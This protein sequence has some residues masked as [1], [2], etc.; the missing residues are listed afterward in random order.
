MGFPIGVG[1]SEYQI[2][3]IQQ[4]IA[5]PGFDFAFERNGAGRRL[6]DN[7]GG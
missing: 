2:H 1:S 7:T 4:T 5:A 3:G 6:P